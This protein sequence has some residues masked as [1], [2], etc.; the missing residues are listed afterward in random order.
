MAWND[1][2][3]ILHQFKEGDVLKIAINIESREYNNKWYTDVK[4]W[5]M[6]KAGDSSP[7]ENPG[8]E[9]SAGSDPG[10]ETSAPVNDDLP[11]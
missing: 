3:D 5:K 10:I 4:A 11:F 1:K 6:E 2:V 9:H 8:M 7:N